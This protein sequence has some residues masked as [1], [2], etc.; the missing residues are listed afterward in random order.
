MEVPAKKIETIS[1]LSR[2]ITL[3]SDVIEFC[4]KN[5]IPVFFGDNSGN[6]IG[7]LQRPLYGDA[8]TGILQL[9]ALSDGE[10]ALELAKAFV[11]GKIK[12][13]MNLLKYYRR[14]RKKNSAYGK[15]VQEALP[16]MKAK[17]HS[18][19]ALGLDG[20]GYP[21]ARSRLMVYEAAAANDYWSRIQL[22]IE[23][24]VPDFCGRNR[25]GAKDL[26]NNLLNYG[27][28]FLYR[29][30]WREVINRGLNPKISFLHAPQGEK[31]TLVYDLVEE[32]RQQA[33]D[34][35]VFSMLTRKEEFKVNKK[36]GLL[37]NKSRNKLLDGLLERQGA[38][39]QYHG[40]KVQ[41]KNIMKAQVQRLK[42]HLKGE[43]D[44]RGFIGYY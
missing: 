40:E 27:Y 10:T 8:I 36:S 5:D 37:N 15:A 38:I 39:M 2:G 41:F 43:T 19:E 35:V 34:R 22:L 12:N 44:Y 18:I 7:M 16:G 31:P 14:H 21:E 26:V 6:P 11:T 4:A 29:Q 17:L 3:S 33:V 20:G 32:F 9:Q 42:Q 1:V 28:G 23:G 13:Q 30:I 25:R 24:V